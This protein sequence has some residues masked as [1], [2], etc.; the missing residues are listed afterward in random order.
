MCVRVWAGGLSGSGPFRVSAPC[1]A[2]L[3]APLAG[4]PQNRIIMVRAAGLGRDGGRRCAREATTARRS[5]VGKKCRLP[6]AREAAHARQLREAAI[7]N[8]V[9]VCP[10]GRLF[11]WD[12]QTADATLSAEE[13]H[14]AQAWLS[15]LERSRTRRTPGAHCRLRPTC[16]QDSASG[17]RNYITAFD[18]VGVEDR[19]LHLSSAIN[20]E[21][22]TPSAVHFRIAYQQHRKGSASGARGQAPGESQRTSAQIPLLQHDVSVH[23]TGGVYGEAEMYEQESGYADLLQWRLSYQAHRSGAAKGSRGEIGSG[24]SIAAVR[25]LPVAREAAHVRQL[26]DA[27]VAKEETV[28]PPSGEPVRAVHVHVGAG[29]LGLGLVVPALTRG[30]RANRGTLI[31]LQRP[32]GAWSACKHGTVVSFTV[33]AEVM[34]RMKVVRE[35]APGEISSLL[36]EPWGDPTADDHVDGLL[37]L[38]QEPELLDQITPLT[39]SLSCALGPALE[40][41]LD[42]LLES[43]G[44]VG[45]R[46]LCGG[47]LRLYAAENDHDAVE[48]LGAKPELAQLQIWVIPLL[49]DRVCTNR[50]ISESEIGISSE[51]WG[52]RPPRLPCPACS[53][54]TRTRPRTAAH[55]HARVPQ[56]RGPP[57]PLFPQRGRDRDDDSRRQPS[58]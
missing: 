21:M 26:R 51:E 14:E 30:A 36:M 6:V 35:A 55:E 7:A 41:G 9:H 45:I 31:I 50:F 48:K 8:D 38:S 10:G 2:N 17:H 25:M 18:K 32:S 12:G 28:S 33:N 49:V 5:R 56:P 42:P 47:W 43:V 19:A 54:R 20:R 37:V 23:G 13:Q 4:R 1:S 29:R 22:A 40:T 11:T 53:P 27:A 58:G 46:H 3:K 57:V 15:Q 16:H 44:R 24:L 34:C 52:A 39:T